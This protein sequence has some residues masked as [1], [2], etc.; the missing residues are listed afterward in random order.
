MKLR[1]LIN[2][3]KYQKIINLSCLLAI[4]LMIFS[5][6]SQKSLTGN[7]LLRNDKPKDLVSFEKLIWSKNTDNTLILNKANLTRIYRN[8]KS[9]EDDYFSLLR[10]YS[11]RLTTKD[12]KIANDLSFSE[13]AFVVG[14]VI[15]YLY[16]CRKKFKKED[17]F[18]DS[19]F[20]N[21]VLAPWDINDYNREFKMHDYY[22]LKL[23]KKHHFK[24]YKY[25]PDEL[26]ESSPSMNKPID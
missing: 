4:G 24:Y 2:I 22:G 9:S 8:T 14:H 1:Y 23:L 18:K 16:K 15:E 5:C 6:G 10:S 11:S 13:R 12:R 19:K 20:V 17:P 25:F 7:N 3:F 21:R 26:Y